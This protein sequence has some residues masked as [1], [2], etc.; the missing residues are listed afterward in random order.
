MSGHS[1][2]ANI[3]H[4]KE[5]NDAAKGK[6][7][8]IIGREIA[9]AVKEGGSDPA[10]NSRLRDVIAKAKANNMPNDTIDRGIKKAAGDSN[11]VNYEYVSYEGYGPGGIAIIVDAL[12]DNKNR[13]AANVRSAFTKGSGSIGTQGCVSYM[14]D[15]K[16]QIIVDKEECEM[17][18]D[19][20]MMLALDAGAEDFSEEDD[21]YEIITDPDA[22]SA[23]REVLEKEGLAMAEASVTMIP[24][25]YVDLTEETAVKNLQKTLDLLDDDDDVQ[26]VYHNWN[27]PTTP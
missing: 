21:C 20:L 2:F 18:A 3:K 6:I 13:T 26:S 19:D 27:E 12:T 14:F 25:N 8:T 17:D 5:K 1:K 4:K 23:V 24:Q 11:A 7:F 9:V 15:K 10:N 22:F 16:G